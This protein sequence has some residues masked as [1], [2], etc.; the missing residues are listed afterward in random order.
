[1][2]V[3]SLIFLRSRTAFDRFL[4][5]H[6]PVYIIL[7]YSKYTLFQFSLYKSTG[8]SYVASAVMMTIDVRTDPI[9][10]EMMY[11]E[12]TYFDAVVF[13]VILYL[14]GSCSREWSKIKGRTGLLPSCGMVTDVMN[15]DRRCYRHVWAVASRDC[16][17]YHLWRWPKS[18]R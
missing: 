16:P 2:N 15:V 11:K 14:D 7:L 18:F 3:F 6:T 13:F 8:V 12:G 9:P 1:M 17:P 10:M 5:S 4:C